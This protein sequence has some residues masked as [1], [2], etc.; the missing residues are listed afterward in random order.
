MIFVKSI[1]RSVPP[2]QHTSPLPVSN[3]HSFHACVQWAVYCIRRVSR[4]RRAR[5]HPYR[6]ADVINVIL[7]FHLC[8]V[9]SSTTDTL[10]ILFVTA[11]EKLSQL[12]MFSLSSIFF[13]FFVI[14][15]HWNKPVHQDSLEYIGSYPKE[16]KLFT[17]T[18]NSCKH[19]TKSH[20]D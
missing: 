6:S 17:P 7:C 3:W 9:N 16:E 15:V 2:P 20:F 12:L 10:Q 18:F 8:S 13:S 11:I 5:P 1:S 14:N 19:P 4:S